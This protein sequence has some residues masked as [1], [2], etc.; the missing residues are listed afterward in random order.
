MES[1]SIYCDLDN[2][3]QS[4]ISACAEIEVEAISVLSS[5]ESEMERA[6]ITRSFTTFFKDG[7]DDLS[8]QLLKL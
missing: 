1:H 7:N 4:L 5:L 2:I 6:C 8:E 3:D